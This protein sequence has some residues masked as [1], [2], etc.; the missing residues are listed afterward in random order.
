M[1]VR[2]IKTHKSPSYNLR[3]VNGR[4]IYPRAELLL[5]IHTTAGYLAGDLATLCNPDN[6]VSCTDLISTEDSIGDGFAD[7]YQLIPRKARSWAQKGANTATD[8][9]IEISCRSKPTRREWKTERIHQ[10]RSSALIYSTLAQRRRRPIPVRHGFPGALGH[11]D[12]SPANPLARA[13]VGDGNWEVWSR[14]QNHI[15]PWDTFPWVTF[16][17]LTEEF[18]AKKMTLRNQKVVVK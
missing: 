18:V 15:D 11:F 10:L 6:D 5:M 1:A 8:T 2:L 16:I 14:G 3:R 4:R 7:I 17:E 9:A 13:L 12:L